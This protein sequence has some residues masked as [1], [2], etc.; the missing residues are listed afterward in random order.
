MIRIFVNEIRS[1]NLRGH[2]IYSLALV[3]IIRVPYLSIGLFEHYEKERERDS[4]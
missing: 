4:T 3:V 1:S 2:L